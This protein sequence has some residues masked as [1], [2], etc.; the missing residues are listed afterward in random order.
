MESKLV[1][2]Y[3]VGLRDIRDENKRIITSSKVQVQIKLGA[4]NIDSK[5]VQLQSSGCEMN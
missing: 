5:E 3:I 4:E 2:V 1:Q